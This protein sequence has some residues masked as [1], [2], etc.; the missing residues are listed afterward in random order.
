MGD[1]YAGEAG[2]RG[3]VLAATLEFRGHLPC[4]VSQLRFPGS[5][6]PRAELWGSAC[7]LAFM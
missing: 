4:P 3:S 7:F 2:N 5:A 6:A 1:R